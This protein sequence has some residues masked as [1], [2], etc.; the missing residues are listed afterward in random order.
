[1]PIE[2]AEFGRTGHHT[3]EKTEHGPHTFNP[4]ERRN[5][6]HFGCARIAKTDFDTR[7]DKRPQQTF[8]AVHV[9]SSPS[10]DFPDN[11]LEVR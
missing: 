9:R 4:I 10:P 3:F 11:S 2:Q 7:S 6:V 5:E 1:M 8:C